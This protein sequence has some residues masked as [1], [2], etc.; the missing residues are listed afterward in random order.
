M[1]FRRPART[2]WALWRAERR[3][4]GQGL[5]ALV[6]STAAGFVAGLTL[7]RLDPD[8]HSVP[9]VTRVMDLAGVAA[10]LLA[11]TALGVG[12]R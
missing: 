10:F 12:V 1:A 8:D 6:L 4:L 2:L 11:M 5:V 7:A 3:T 9:I